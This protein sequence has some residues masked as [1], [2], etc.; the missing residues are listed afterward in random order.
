[1][2]KPVRPIRTVL[3]DR[4]EPTHGAWLEF[5]ILIKI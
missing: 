4:K 3:R 2:K 5:T 1:M